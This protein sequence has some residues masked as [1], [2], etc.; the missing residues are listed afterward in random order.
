MNQQTSTVAAAVIALGFTVFSAAASGQTTRWNSTSGFPFNLWS[1]GLNWTNG[2][3]TGNSDAFIDNGGT[4]EILGSR[5]D[6]ERLFVGGDA[7]QGHL[8]INSFLNTGLLFCSE[9]T[10][11]AGTAGGSVE[12]FNASRLSVLS[13]GNLG[14]GDLL[15]GNRGHGALTLNNSSTAFVE[16]LHVGTLNQPGTGTVSI[17]TGSE[18][19]VSDLIDIHRGSITVSDG[20]TLTDSFGSGIIIRQNGELR[21]GS[22]GNVGVVNSTVPV[23]LGGALR[24]DHGGSYAF[25]QIVHGTGQIVN[26]AGTTSLS[27]TSIDAFQGSLVS[28]GGVLILGGSAPLSS[29]R[30][31]D[32]GTV[33]YEGFAMNGGFLRGNGT[34]ELASGFSNSFSGTTTFASTRIEQYGT[35][36]LTNFFNGGTLTSNNQLTLDGLVNTSSGVIHVNDHTDASDFSTNGVLNVNAGGSIQNSAGSLVAGGGS[37]TFINAGG[38]VQL[39]NNTEFELNGG[40]LVNNGTI[41]GTLNVNYGSLAKG[42]GTFGTVNVTDGGT[43]SPGN[44]P[45]SVTV[46]SLILDEGSEL[47]FEIRDMEGLAGIGFDQI[48]ATDSICLDGGM[49]ANSRLTISIVSLDANNDPGLAANFDPG[50][51]YLFDFLTAANGIVGFSADTIRLDTSLFLNDPNTRRFQVS[52]NGSDLS[53]NYSAVPEPTGCSLLLLAGLASAMRRRR[54]RNASRIAEPSIT[55]PPQFTK[56]H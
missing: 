44:S 46:D 36:T 48:L 14:N 29:I 13:S 28:N 45:D 49:T 7:L 3:P 33:R 5:G 22:G 19:M 17:R 39:L 1:D 41:D 42:A 20:G 38:Q 30:A 12:V 54:R 43:F 21:I 9:L 25:D 24:F 23:Q 11:G 35:A 18:L 10:I 56:G 31:N 37:R 53:L 40:L 4:A 55:A 51:R 16:S 32:S 2:I 15:V 50:G 26:D 6:A 52:T 8:Q 47:V 34:H 27:S